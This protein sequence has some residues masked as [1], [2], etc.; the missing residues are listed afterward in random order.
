MFYM[1]E[2]E[3]EN[4]NSLRYKKD[5]EGMSKAR[6]VDRLF[7]YGGLTHVVKHILEDMWVL[8]MNKR[9]DESEALRRGASPTNL[10]RE[11]G[12]ED[13][14]KSSSEDVKESYTYPD[15]Y[16]DEYRRRHEED[17]I[18]RELVR[19]ERR[20]AALEQKRAVEGSQVGE[21]EEGLLEELDVEWSKVDEQIN[22]LMEE[23]DDLK[24]RLRDGYKKSRASKLMVQRTSELLGTTAEELLGKEPDK[25]AGA[26]ELTSVE[27]SQNVKEGD[28][29]TVLSNLE[30]D[31]VIPFNR[32]IIANSKV[33]MENDTKASKLRWERQAAKDEEIKNRMDALLNKISS[34]EENRKK[35]VEDVDKDENRWRKN[36]MDRLFAEKLNEFV[37][38]YDEN[39][40]HVED[41]VEEEGNRLIDELNEE[42]AEMEKKEIEQEERHQE[43]EERLNEAREHV[44]GLLNRVV[45]IGNEL[46]NE[47]DEEVVKSRPDRPIDFR[48]ADE[49]SASM[50]PLS[51][52]V[53]QKQK[54]KDPPPEPSVNVEFT[55]ALV[56]AN[57]KG[58]QTYIEDALT[59]LNRSSIAV[60]DDIIKEQQALY[61]HFHS[62]NVRQIKPVITAS[63]YSVEEKQEE[64][65]RL[66]NELKQA[67]DVKTDQQQRI[68]T[69][70]RKLKEINNEFND[71]TERLKNLMEKEE[72]MQE[73]AEKLHSKWK[74]IEKQKEGLKKQSFKLKEQLTKITELQAEK[75]NELVREYDGKAAAM[76]AL[77]KQH[78]KKVE[79]DVVKKIGNTED[80]TEKKLTD[81]ERR[82]K[83]EMKD[84]ERQI[85]GK[86][87]EYEKRLKNTLEE[88]TQ[89]CNE[90]EK[91][92]FPELKKLQ[93]E[94]QQKAEEITKQLEKT[95]QILE[96]HEK[97]VEERKD[98]LGKAED[99]VNFFFFFFFF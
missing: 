3:A 52:D 35:V 71:L 11:E 84:K 82:K 28:E 76:L 44:D 78:T 92:T 58:L 69:V 13:G 20:K 24:K 34:I 1:P 79:R 64:V 2:S 86:V 66:N 46:L 14:A 12:G 18:E 51:S 55:P 32:N 77:I 6:G 21:G 59:E 36:R 87:N 80:D 4:P 57:N 38:T 95:S 73:D 29:N 27:Q 81:Y 74:N 54:P 19:S 8:V 43:I 30:D 41:F 90:Y 93:E 98:K 31:K 63:L 96:D 75:E 56:T 60:H 67:E 94:I 91:N 62:K 33:K 97:S 99:E 61:D 10:D 42:K 83:M 5:G 7:I 88:D 50:F 37:H 22:K 45:I 72:V 9:I 26:G 53:F 15:Q 40:K 68:E 25:K 16:D 49:N 89:K 70:E 85:M 47:V 39:V 48:F 23:G 65:D 17:D